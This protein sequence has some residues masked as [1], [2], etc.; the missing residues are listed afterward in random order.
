MNLNTLQ[1]ALLLG[2][3]TALANILGSYLAILQYR[4]SRRFTAAALGFS[5][6]FVLA[7]ALLEM[8]P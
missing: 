3:V 6:G 2:L 4:P 8:V 7:A 5:G 1:I